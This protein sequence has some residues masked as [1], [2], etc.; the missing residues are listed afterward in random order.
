MVKKTGSVQFE[1]VEVV[2]VDAE[3]LGDTGWN[4]LKSQLRD[5]KKPCPV[6]R[7]VGYMV[8]RSDTHISLLSTMGKDLASTLE[9]IPTGFIISVATLKASKDSQ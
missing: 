5:A 4:N 7:S 1:I 9:K 2:W 8:H 6:M 3:E